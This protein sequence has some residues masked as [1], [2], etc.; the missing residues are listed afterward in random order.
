LR[1][2]KG[3]V[4]RIVVFGPI[5]EYYHPL[6]RLLAQI[7]DG[8]SEDLLNV[9]RD[10]TQFGLDKLVRDAVIAQGVSYV[11]AY[12]IL[13][14]NE[15]AACV[16]MSNGAPVQWDYGHLTAAGSSFLVGQAKQMGTLDVG[17]SDAAG[18]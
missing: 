13:C 9:G 14:P 12:S 6:P 4:R 18:N 10:V 11:S 8:R 16:T 17:V 15:A 1:D 5:V 3:K 7:A 2:L